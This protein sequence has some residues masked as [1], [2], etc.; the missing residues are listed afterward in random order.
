MAKLF[1]LCHKRDT[2]LDRQRTSL[3]ERGYG[4]RYRIGKEKGKVTAKE[5]V[6]SGK[7]SLPLTL[8]V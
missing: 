4:T 1:N 7:D 2:R 5:K 6:G 8:D 3:G